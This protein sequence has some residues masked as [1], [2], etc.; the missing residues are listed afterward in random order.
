MSKKFGLR[1]MLGTAAFAAVLAFGLMAVGCDSDSDT[2]PEYIP[3]ENKP[4]AERWAKWVDASST[5]TLDY[6]VAA[7]GVATITVGGTQE[8]SN[9]KANA[10]YKYTAEAGKK[11]KYTFEAWTASGT[12]TVGVQYYSKNSVSLSL[13]AQTLTTTHQTFTLVGNA[14]PVSGESRLEFQCANTLGIFYV[15][16]ISI[17]E[18]TEAST[19]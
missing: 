11:Y 4:V 10:G 9:W 2:G 6:S 3:P 8:S 13:P 12:R 19:P 14:I 15:K 17:G 18:T 7:D 5:A 1:T 16:V